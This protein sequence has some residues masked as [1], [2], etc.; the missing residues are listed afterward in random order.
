MVWTEGHIQTYLLECSNF[1]HRTLITG[2][3]STPVLSV[4]M[5]P[6]PLGRRSEHPWPV[7][8]LISSARI[9][10]YTPYLRAMPRRVCVRSS[11]NVDGQ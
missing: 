2:W 9:A 3:L 4:R 5:H 10:H 6:G 7:Q 11:I 8:P 1:G